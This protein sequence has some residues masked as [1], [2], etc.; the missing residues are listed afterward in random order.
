[1]LDFVHKRE[2]NPF[3][4]SL[5]YGGLEDREETMKWMQSARDK[6]IPWFPWLVTWFPQTKSMHDDP[7]MQQFAAELGIEF[8][9]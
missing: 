5:I 6:K 8:P 9:D 4:L 2:N 3:T 7:R 1:M